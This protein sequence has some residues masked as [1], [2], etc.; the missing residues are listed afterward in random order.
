VRY[1]LLFSAVSALGIIAFIPLAR[2]VL[3]LWVGAPIAVQVLPIL[4]PLLWTIGNAAASAPSNHIL[5]AMGHSKFA[6]AAGATANTLVLLLM[7]AGGALFGLWGVIGG[8][9]VALPL[10]LGIR[11]VT[12]ARIFGLPRPVRT[13]FTM[14]WPTLAGGLVVLPLSWYLLVTP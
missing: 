13:A 8:K 9:L 4:L 5:N 3:D 7:V 6:A 2:P 12:A 10:S 11:A 1:T 14:L